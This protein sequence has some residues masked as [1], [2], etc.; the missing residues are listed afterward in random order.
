MILLGQTSVNLESLSI[1]ETVTFAYVTNDKTI[2]VQLNTCKFD[3]KW[4]IQVGCGRQNKKASEN[5][6]MLGV[7]IESK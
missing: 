1:L 6:G 3:M 7:T 2:F 5:I 4:A